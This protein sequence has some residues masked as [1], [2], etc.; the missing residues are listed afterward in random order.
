MTRVAYFDLANGIAGDMILAA[1]AH[2]GRRIGVDVAS[3]IG[4]TVASLDLDCAVT[5][6]DDE[7][8]GIA[9]LRAEVKTDGRRYTAKQLREAIEKV[10]LTEGA[11]LRALRAMEALVGA[12]AT[13]HGTDPTEVHLHEL[14][15][16]DTAADIVGASAAFA[17]LGISRVVAAPVPVPHGS[18]HTEHGELPLPAPVTLELLAGAALRGVDSSH[19]LVTPTG[20]AILVA[21]DT[22][23]GPLPDITLAAVGVAGGRRVTDAPN[24][25]R[26]LI[27]SDASGSSLETCVLLET[28]I[29][30]QTPEAV[31]YAIEKL[32]GAGA[33]DA[34]VTPIVMKKS[35]PAFLLSVL[36]AHSHEA[37][38]TDV[39]FRETTTLGIRRR[40]T[41][42]W[43]L[44]RE[45]LTVEVAGSRIRVKIGRLGSEVVNVAP[46]F[47]DCAAA[48]EESGATA[49]DV[50]AEATQRARQ[51]LGT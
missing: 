37:R 44:E 26:V 45:V 5:F 50:Y 33:L 38:V 35:R 32:L 19:E 20:A 39:I 1:L 9:C 22:T 16:A 11:R 8:G 49:K 3:T 13:V 23:F 15:S 7:R 18:V 21:H 2:A 17:A 29:D 14:A 25:C 43:V 42:R 31:G 27:G 48:A 4:E 12:E 10:E 28:N 47:S 51:A 30:D 24:I 34:W 36:A 40:D 41:T 6:V 46:E